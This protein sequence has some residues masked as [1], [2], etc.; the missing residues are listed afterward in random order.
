M[1]PQAQTRPHHHCQTRFPRS[2]QWQGCCCCC[3]PLDRLHTCCLLLVRSRK[4]LRLLLLGCCVAV[5][6]GCLLSA[7][8]THLRR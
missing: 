5:T 1:Q 6:A 8:E 7:V 3:W 2:R 4:D